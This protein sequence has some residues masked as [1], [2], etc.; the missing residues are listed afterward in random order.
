VSNDKAA[1]TYHDGV[2]PPYLQQRV[3]VARI[4]AKYIAEADAVLDSPR[5]A[6]L[7]ALR[8]EVLDVL[9]PTED[10]DIPRT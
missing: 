9:D 3:A 4:F 1:A 2:I 8:A 6:I 5:A 10:G 7:E